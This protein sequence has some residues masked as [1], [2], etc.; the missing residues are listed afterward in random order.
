M[1]FWIMLGIWALVFV[2]ALILELTTTQLVSIWF[3]G[4]SLIALCM[5]FFNIEWWIQIIIFV[6]SSAILL[7]LSQYLLRGKLKG[8]TFKT[9]YDTI[10]GEEIVVLKDV[11]LLNKGEAKVRDVIWTIAVENNISIKQGEI[12]LVKEIKGNKLIVTRKD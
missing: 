5:A 3:C 7:V 6:V 11:S 4:S 12:A 2:I 10:I 1:T 8:K 9:N